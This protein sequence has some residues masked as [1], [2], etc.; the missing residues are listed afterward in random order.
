MTSLHTSPFVDGELMPVFVYGTLQPGEVRWFALDGKVLVPEGEPDTVRG[1]LW[2][3]G[4]DYPALT[5]DEPAVSVPGHVLRLLPDTAIDTWTLLVDIEG[6]V[7]S[8]YQPQIITTESG[9]RAL[10]FPYSAAPP[11]H[12]VAI[13][14]WRHGPQA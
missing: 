9:V 7:D 12:F 11:D 5:L 4:F 6:G 10:A 3:T 13:T 2:D 14:R 8:S 1:R